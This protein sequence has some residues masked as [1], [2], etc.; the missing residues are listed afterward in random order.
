M[1]CKTWSQTQALM[2]GGGVKTNK[3]NTVH[4]QWS[5]INHLI[6]ARRSYS[7]ALRLQLSVHQTFSHSTLIH[8]CTSL[9]YFTPSL[10]QME[11]NKYPLHAV[12]FTVCVICSGFT[13]MRKC[14]TVQLSTLTFI[15]FLKWQNKLEFLLQKRL[16]CLL[17]QLNYFYFHIFVLHLK[18]MKMKLYKPTNEGFFYTN[19]IYRFVHIFESLP[20][21]QYFS[22]FSPFSGSCAVFL[23]QPHDVV[24]GPEQPVIRPCTI[25]DQSTPPTA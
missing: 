5:S 2:D 17:C 1:R 4:W 22:Y 16:V 19:K 23:Q 8:H 6:F 24:V 7:L 20:F 14:Q 13:V 10:W 11:I 9:Q 3:Q 12:S 25:R 21:V 18:K 15:L